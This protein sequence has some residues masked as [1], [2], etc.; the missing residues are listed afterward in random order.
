MASLLGIGIEAR[1]RSQH[2]RGTVVAEIGEQP[3]AELVAVVDGEVND[4]IESPLRHRA[5]AAWDLVDAVDD[6]VA[7]GDVFIAATKS[8]PAMV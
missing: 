3:L 2:H 5:E 8:V 6:D 4:G 1:G 7:A